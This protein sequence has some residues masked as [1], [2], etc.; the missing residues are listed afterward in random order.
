MQVQVIIPFS[1]ANLAPF[2]KNEIFECPDAEAAPLIKG[3]L[4]R[5]VPVKDPE[6]ATAPVQRKRTAAA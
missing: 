6:F 4:V 1:Q 2:R 3:G 5:P